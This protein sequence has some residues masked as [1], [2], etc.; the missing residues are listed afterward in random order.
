M[1]NAIQPA[2]I[3]LAILWCLASTCSPTTKHTVQPAPEVT[4]TTSTTL[5]SKEAMQVVPS[6]DHAPSPSIVTESQAL[7]PVA[8][9]APY[10]PAASPP[11][12]SAGRWVTVQRPVYGRFGRVRGY[13]AV[14]VFQPKKGR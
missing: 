3:C 10:T 12:R 7:V 13:E 4:T 14:R 6:L 1:K 8:V 5:E 9:E 11:A 2:A